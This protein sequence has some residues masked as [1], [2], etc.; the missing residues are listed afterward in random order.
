M[1]PFEVIGKVRETYRRDGLAV[2]LKEIT[3]K[4]WDYQRAVWMIRE[5]SVDSPKNKPLLP[6]EIDYSHSQE[7]IAW[8]RRQNISGTADHKELDIAIK[9]KHLFPSVKLENKIVGYIKIGFDKVHV[10]DFRRCFDFPAKVAFIFDTYVDPK[11]RGK[12]IAPFLID[13][14]SEFMKEKGY[15][16]IYCHIRVINSASI[17]AYQKCGFKPLRTIR[18]FNFFGL[19]FFS[20]SPERLWDKS[21][22][23]LFGF[24]FA[25]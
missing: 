24:K 25:L 7:T 16:Q 8:I 19:N 14:V 5:L 22:N 3:R 2:V 17:K 18:W 21:T 13:D 1:N 10:L 15:A 6:V 23:K 12:N 11:L 4:I 20:S 9:Y